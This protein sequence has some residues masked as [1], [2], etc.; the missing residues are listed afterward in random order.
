MYACFPFAVIR[1]WLVRRNITK[2]HHSKQL[3]SENVKPKSKPGRRI[4]DVKVLL[5]MACCHLPK[6]CG[7]LTE[8][9]QQFYKVLVLS[10]S[11]FYCSH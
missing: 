9:K 3:I 2:M 6:K 5:I 4:S 8:A 7:T 11:I 1:G 10:C